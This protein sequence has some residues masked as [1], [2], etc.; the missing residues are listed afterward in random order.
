MKTKTEAKKNI[1]SQTIDATG[2]KLGRLASEVAVI[3]MGKDSSDFERHEIAE[4]QI[5]IENISKL[6]INEKKLQEKIYVTYT[7]YPGGLNK[8]TLKEMVEK[9]GYREA[10][11]EAVR[12]MLPKN[13]HRDRLIKRLKITE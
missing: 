7:G 3:L 5:T 8:Q 13:T 10:F 2:K 12:G 4:R 1:A 6:D 11:V 9:K